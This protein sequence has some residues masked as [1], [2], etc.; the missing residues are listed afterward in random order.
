ME[1]GSL[2]DVVTALTAIGALVAAIIGAR[3]ASR[4]FAVE[5]KRDR[6]TAEREKQA[7]ASRVFAW[8][9]ARI[10]DRDSAK[11]GVVV[12]N[13]SE[14]AIYDVKVRVIGANAVER[15]AITLAFL[16]PGSFY[17]E[18][19]HEAYGWKF[20]SRIE[21]IT[22]EIRPVAKAKKRSIAGMWFR[23][24]SNLKWT[25]DETGI[26]AAQPQ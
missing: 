3:H 7:Q 22:D 11:Y 6:S 20:A 12:V 9:A 17:L 21:T 14:Q 16:P 26:L 1:L 25:R 19:S 15:S 24:S 5:A 23:D 8:V 18:E 10:I 4:L 13:S 2:A